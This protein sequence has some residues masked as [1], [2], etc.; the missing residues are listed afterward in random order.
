MNDTVLQGC[1]FAIDVF[2]VPIRKRGLCLAEF[3]RAV[4]SAFDGPVHISKVRPKD[5]IADNLGNGGRLGF[6]P[7]LLPPAA[8]RRLAKACRRAGGE[9]VPVDDNPIDSV[10][11]DQPPPPLAPVVAHPVEYAVPAGAEIEV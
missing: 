3:L 9:L 1:E 10:W 2:T 5:W 7:W 4:L 8:V 11:T 6:D